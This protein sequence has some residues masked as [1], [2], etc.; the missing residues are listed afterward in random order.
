MLRTN[1]YYLQVP[2]RIIDGRVKGEKRSY[3]ILAHRFYKDSTVSIDVK[4]ERNQELVDFD[5][6]DFNPERSTECSYTLKGNVITIKDPGPFSQPYDMIVEND[7]LIHL[8]SQKKSFFVPWDEVVSGEK[9]MIHRLFGPLDEG[10]FE[11]RYE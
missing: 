8:K 1:G 11:I 3:L 10:D 7:T 4:H 2:L 5:R 9:K 6:S